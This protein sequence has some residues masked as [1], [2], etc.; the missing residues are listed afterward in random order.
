MSLKDKPYYFLTDRSTL[1]HYLVDNRDNKKARFL[2]Y[3]KKYETMTSQQMQRD[4]IKLNGKL[5]MWSVFNK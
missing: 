4:Q 2:Y 1:M 5:L 3:P